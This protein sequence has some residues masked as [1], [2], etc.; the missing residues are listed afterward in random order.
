M[1]FFVII[2][3]QEVFWHS[4]RL[5]SA[6]RRI[7]AFVAKKTFVSF[8]FFVVKIKKT[9]SAGRHIKPI[10]VSKFLSALAPLRET[11]K[12]KCR[13]HAAEK[14]HEF[15]HSWRLVSAVRRIRAFVAKKVQAP[16]VRSKKIFKAIKICRK[17]YIAHSPFNKQ[18]F[19]PFPNFLRGTATYFQL[20]NYFF[21]LLTFLS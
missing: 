16:Q 17:S 11:K 8:V 5:M 2:P 21:L 1:F 12:C 3:Q 19:D 10:C 20:F 15:S 4:W 7:R 18:P 6:V 13:R 14:I 9:E